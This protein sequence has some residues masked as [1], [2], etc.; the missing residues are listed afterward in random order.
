MEYYC[1]RHLVY[2]ARILLRCQR[3]NSGLPKVSPLSNCSDFDILP[4]PWPLCI[5]APLKG[6]QVTGALFRPKGVP[7]C[8]VYFRRKQYPKRQFNLYGST[9]CWPPV[10]PNA[11][12]DGPR[13]T[14]Q[15]VPNWIV[16]VCSARSLASLDGNSKGSYY[17][18]LR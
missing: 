15:G 3:S 14:W 4:G 8:E 12:H 2:T 10:C 11:L 13:N 6:K 7:R 9:S 17:Y 18:A 16:I 5:L 1:S